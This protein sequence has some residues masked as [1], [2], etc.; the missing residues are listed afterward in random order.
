[1]IA[2][3]IIIAVLTLVALL[4]FGVKAEYSEEGVSV[5]ATAGPF[6]VKIYPRAAKDDKAMEKAKR[7]AEKKARRKAAKK[8]LKKE[9]AP[10]ISEEDQKE[11]KAGGFDYFKVILSS[12]GKALGR[13]R[14]RL[15]VKKLTIRFISGN[16]DPS[17]AALA[18]GA[19]NAAFGVITPMLEK[20][21]RIR[22]RDFSASA[23]FCSAKPKIYVNAAFSLAVWEVFYLAFALLPLL[24]K[25]PGKS[26]DESTINDI[27]T[28]GK[29]GQ[30]NGQTPD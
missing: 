5:A 2:L 10:K 4:R 29:E 25:R 8:A 26:N 1:M 12:S 15:L 17:K 7:K 18:F 22:R 13:L 11:K 19:A 30:E 6:T 14:R 27:K 3:A 24:T 16:G 21:F 20:S 23:D 9:K 28:T